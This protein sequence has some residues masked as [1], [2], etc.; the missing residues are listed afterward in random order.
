MKNKYD[1]KS[2][3]DRAESRSLTNTNISSK[4]RRSE[5]IPNILDLSI[6]WITGEK[7]GYLS[8]SP[9]WLESWEEVDDLRRGRTTLCQT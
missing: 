9:L 5:I 8:Q 2:R 3:E 1:I 6:N 7:L 4:E